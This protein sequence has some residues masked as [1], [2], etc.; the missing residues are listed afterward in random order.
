MIGASEALSKTL[1]GLRNTLDP[2]IKHEN[3]DKYKR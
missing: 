2:E 3:E 1:W